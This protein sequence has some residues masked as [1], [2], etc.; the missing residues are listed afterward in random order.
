LLGT[1]NVSKKVKGAPPRGGKKENIKERAMKG[2]RSF[3]DAMT[4]R[5]QHE[6]TGVTQ[7]GS[8]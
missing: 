3:V 2:E 4:N 8:G 7:K 5:G 6:T 1:T